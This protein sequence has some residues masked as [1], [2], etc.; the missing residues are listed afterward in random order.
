[1]WSS[2]KVKLGILT[3][4][5]LVIGL[6]AC[7]GEDKTSAKE[8]VTTGKSEATAGVE[9]FLLARGEEPGYQP[10]GPVTKVS[11]LKE[12]P[13]HLRARARLLRDRG[14]VSLVSRP[15]Q[16][17]EGVGVTSLLLFTNA[18][19]ARREAAQ[20]RRDL[21]VDFRGWT[22]KRFDVTGVPGAFG[23]TA[24]NGSH[25]VGN[26]TWVE[27]RC[28]MTLGN[29][30]ESSSVAPLRAGVQAVHRRVAGRCP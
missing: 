21:E 9:R 10:G 4:A 8:A 24:R 15:L 11:S 17:K 1:M 19:G 16:G 23:S 5:T 20:Q 26:V 13:P 27:G 6:A 25:R 28:V 22:V 18:A 30:A 3:M 7:G 12:L 2:L 29:E 14:F